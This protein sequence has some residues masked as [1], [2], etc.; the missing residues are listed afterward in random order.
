MSDRYKQHIDAGLLCYIKSNHMQGVSRPEQEKRAI[1]IKRNEIARKLTLE[2]ND[3][4]LPGRQ[5]FQLKLVKV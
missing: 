4:A 3:F 5:C 1:L 2:K